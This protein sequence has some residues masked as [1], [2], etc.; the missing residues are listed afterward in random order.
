MQPALI[1]FFLTSLS[2]YTF[3]FFFPEGE[4]EGNHKHIKFYLPDVHEESYPRQAIW[5]TLGW[6]SAL[7]PLDTHSNGGCYSKVDLPWCFHSVHSIVNNSKNGAREWLGSMLQEKFHH[8]QW[9]CFDSIK[10][11]NW[12]LKQ[13]TMSVDTSRRLKQHCPQA[14]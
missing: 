6:R 11:H 13:N 7:L 1:H 4:R 5:C 8:P 10:L 3:V 9:L 2:F 14:K 12:H